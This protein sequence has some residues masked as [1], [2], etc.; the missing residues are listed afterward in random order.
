MV[1][2]GGS[3]GM[4]WMGPPGAFCRW[5]T[6]S[7][8][9]DTR[10]LAEP[11]FVF[12]LAVYQVCPLCF[13]KAI[14]YRIR[15]CRRL[16]SFKRLS[17]D[18]TFWNRARIHCYFIGSIRRFKVEVT[19]LC[20]WSLGIPTWHSSC[21]FLLAKGSKRFINDFVEASS[22]LETTFVSIT[23]SHCHEYGRTIVTCIIAMQSISHRTP[24]K[25]PSIGGSADTFAIVAWDDS[26][27]QHHAKFMLIWCG[28]GKATIYQSNHTACLRIAWY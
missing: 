3:N 27:F 26:S 25:T 4:R 13:D 18:W 17:E 24:G 2:F 10:T 19:A 20:I 15:F 28:K 1:V 21:M 11:A 14:L 23:L 7:E 8:E 9:I 6:T 12:F 5:A 22:K 16:V